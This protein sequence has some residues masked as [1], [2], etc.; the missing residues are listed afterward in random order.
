MTDKLWEIP[1]PGGH[2]SIQPPLLETNFQT[3]GNWTSPEGWAS[4]MQKY[5]RALDWKWARKGGKAEGGDRK[6]PAQ[7]VVLL[8]STPGPEWTLGNPCGHPLPTFQVLNTFCFSLRVYLREYDSTASLPTP[9]F[10]PTLPCL[11]V[12]PRM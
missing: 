6:M 7:L 8:A 4:H 5:E 2:T 1:R 12:L 11:E 3:L 10:S 9:V